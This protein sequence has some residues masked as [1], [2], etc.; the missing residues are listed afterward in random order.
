MGSIPSQTNTHAMTLD[1]NNLLSPQQV[2][3]RLGVTQ[4]TVYNWLRS[5]K[6]RGKKFGGVWRVHARET[7][8]SAM[9]DGA[10]VPDEM[11]SEESE[12]E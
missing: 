1:N 3:Q 9:P 2:A 8:G 7:C 4:R 6:L 5:G 11:S 12:D 10:A